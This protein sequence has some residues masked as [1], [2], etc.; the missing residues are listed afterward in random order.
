MPERHKN[1]EH[2]ITILHREAGNPENCI[3]LYQ[4]DFLPGALI[5]LL[6]EYY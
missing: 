6:I 2:E 3:S 5:H 4:S 1:I